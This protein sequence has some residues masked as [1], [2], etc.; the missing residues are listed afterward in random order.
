MSL[1]NSQIMG[2]SILITLSEADSSNQA[3]QWIH[4]LPTGKFFANDGRG[5]FF[6]ENA[7]EIVAETMK[8]A[9]SKQIP[10]DYDHQIDHATKNGQP[11][12]AAGWIS[13]FES[14]DNGIWG[15]VEWT[16]RARAYLSAKEYR[17]LSPVLNNNEK[18]EVICIR[19]AALTNKPALELT[20]LCSEQETRLA[21]E[22]LATQSKLEEALALAESIQ[23]EA[24]VKEAE[25]LVH[26][27]AAEG[28]ILPFQKD[29]ATKLCSVDTGLFEEF[30]S[31]VSPSNM[32]LFKE[33]G[34]GSLQETEH[35]Q[36]LSE[37]E[38]AICKAMGHTHEEFT[39]LG[40]SN[41]H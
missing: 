22:L 26:M 38:Q 20:A 6:V 25:S 19:R 15:L 5:P 31:M 17:Y 24:K 36:T 7:A 2:S 8:R 18:G 30:V 35:V 9:G 34:Y 23:K 39:Q 27:A 4:L 14:R 33:F 3:D 12:P 32:A 1:D 13:K 10:V 29:F 11:A 21:T 37:T 28:R 41:D 16:D 40:V